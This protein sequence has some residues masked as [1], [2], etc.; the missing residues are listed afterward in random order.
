MLSIWTV[1]AVYASFFAETAAATDGSH[2]LNRRIISDESRDASLDRSLIV[3]GT[4]VEPGTYPGFAWSLFGRG[5]GCGGTLIHSDIVMTAAHCKIVFESRGLTIGATKVNGSDGEFIEDIL[6]LPH[7]D[8]NTTIESNDIM[9]VKLEAPSSAKVVEWNHHR[10]VPF[11]GETV[12]VIGFGDTIQ[13]GELSESLQEVDIRIINFHTCSAVWSN[14]GVPV[15]HTRQICAGTR[16][17]KDACQGDSGGPLFDKD[18]VQVGIVSFGT[19]CARGGIPG[20]YTRVSAYADW[21]EASI[22]RISNYPPSYCT[23]SPSTPTSSSTISP[24][25]GST[26]SAPSP[27][28]QPSSSNPSRRKPRRTAR[29]TT[30]AFTPTDEIV[31]KELINECFLKVTKQCNCRSFVHGSTCP[32]DTVN[33][34]C[35]E[36]SGNEEGFLACRLMRKM[37]MGFCR[38]QRERMSSAPTGRSRW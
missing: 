16:I 34:D 36:L 33:T 35:Q 14:D 26:I 25:S 20:V 9:L 19:G 38:A 30:T 37:Y 3:G 31:R 32:R 5:A 12:K 17:G 10:S 28:T 15:D 1:G 18:N 13:G 21:I 11:S 6:V 29:P 27:K 4:V 22:C 24:S 8:Y 23:A 2:K 7:P